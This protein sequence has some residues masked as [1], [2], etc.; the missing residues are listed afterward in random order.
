MCLAGFADGCPLGWYITET[1]C[2][3]VSGIL[4]PS[5]LVTWGEAKKKC[6]EVY[7]RA[8]LLT[9]DT[10]QTQVQPV[11]VAT[12]VKQ[13]CIHFPKNANTLK[14]ICIKQAPVLSIGYPF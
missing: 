1:S 8:T 2:F 10:E 13:A 3:W 5:Q 12:S 4:D 11:L 6:Q 14:S 7:N 9:L